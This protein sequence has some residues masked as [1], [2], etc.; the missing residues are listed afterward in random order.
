MWRLDLLRA[1]AAVKM[2]T[3]DTMPTQLDAKQRRR[4]RLVVG[5]FLLMV[6][7][8]VVSHAVPGAAVLGCPFRALSGLSCFGCGMTRSTAHFL[9][10]DLQA[11]LAFHPFGPLFLL[12]F[13]AAALH[14]AVQLRRGRPL[15]Y[16]A[17][18]WWRRIERPVWVAIALFMGIFGLIRF[19]LEMTGFLTPI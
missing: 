2:G 14:H 1:A 3:M 11:A 10:G 9:H 19:V 15:D 12:G 7:Y 13:A 4:G 17:L 18:G 16:R 6:T 5:A 8:L